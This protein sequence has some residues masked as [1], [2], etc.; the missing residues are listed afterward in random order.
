ME[1]T[2][3]PS[4]LRVSSRNHLPSK[5]TR[6]QSLQTAAVAVAACSRLDAQAR[7]VWWTTWQ[8]PAFTCHDHMLDE[9]RAACARPVPSTTKVGYLYIC[10][11]WVWSGNVFQSKVLWCDERR[12]AN[13]NIAATVILKLNLRVIGEAAARQKQTLARWWQRQRHYLEQKQRFER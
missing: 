13:V 11:V 8:R 5:Q 10:T 9:Q 2:S 7:S 4:P 12:S 3:Q 6:A 1:N